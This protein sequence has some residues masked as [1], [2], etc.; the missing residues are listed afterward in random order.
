MWARS[1]LNEPNKRVTAKRNS[2]QTKKEKK[3]KI[4][5]QTTRQGTWII[6]PNRLRI[7]RMVVQWC[8]GI[9]EERNQH[10]KKSHN[11]FSR[12]SAAKMLVVQKKNKRRRRRGAASRVC[13]LFRC[14]CCACMF[15]FVAVCVKQCGHRPRGRTSP[16]AGGLQLSCPSFGRHHIIYYFFLLSSS[17]SSS[18][19]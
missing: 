15:V 8:S 14:V 17:F 6:L 4:N 3:V 13:C 19:V 1:D 16:E 18:F 12:L 2:R 10:N 7:I 5:S 9:Q 11:N